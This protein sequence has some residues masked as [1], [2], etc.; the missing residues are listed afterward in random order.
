MRR[1]VILMMVSA[2][3]LLTTVLYGAEPLKVPVLMEGSMEILWNRGAAIGMEDL[4]KQGYDLDVKLVEKLSRENIEGVIRKFAEQGYPLVVIHTA[5]G[6]DILRQIHNEYP[7]VAFLGGGAAYSTEKPNL[8]VYLTDQ[9]ESAYLCGVIAGMMTKTNV[10][11]IVAAYP[12]IVLNDQ[13][14]GFKRGALSVNP[15]VKVKVSYIESWYDPVKAK[16]ATLAQISVGADY[17]Y[18]ERDGVIQGCQEKGK[19][20]FGAYVDMHDVAP[21]TVITSSMVDFSAP[22]KDAIDKVKSGKFVAKDY[23]KTMAQGGSKLAPYYDFENKL[24]K[25]VKDKVTELSKKIKSGELVIPKEDEPL[26]SD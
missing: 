2:L 1:S 11:G 19:F 8:G 21:D 16:E 7:N 15:D 18:A 13:F 25:E 4:K 24:P 3:V 20:A 12:V 17:I 14:N 5:Q 23:T 10:L 9:H 26:K 6:A 22:F